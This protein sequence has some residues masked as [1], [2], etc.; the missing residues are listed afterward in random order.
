MFSPKIDLTMDQEFQ[1]D[2]HVRSDQSNPTAKYFYLP[3]FEQADAMQKLLGPMPSGNLPPSKPPRDM[4]SYLANLWSVPLLTPEQETHCYTKLNFLRF[5]AD[6]EGRAD[7]EH[8]DNGKIQAERSCI[9]C[10]EMVEV[11]KR[12]FMESLEV[13]NQIVEAN[14]RLVISLAKKYAT[15]GSDAFDEIVCGGNATLLRAVDRFDFRREVRF[16]TYAFQ[17]IQRGIFTDFRKEGRVKSRFPSSGTEAAESA[18]ASAI[19]DV[20]GDVDASE[21]RE[22]V[23]DLMDQLDDR[24]R[25]IVMARFGINRKH[26]GVAFHVIAKEIGLSTTRTMQLFHRSLA[27]MRDRLGKRKKRSKSNRR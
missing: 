20:L 13:R 7:R 11:R 25:E 27:T 26:S 19:A 3:V 17:A 10:E 2:I 8:R 1:S 14:L 9:D 24:D 23:I 22:Q 12:Y 18:V 4:P 5:L 6:P 15:Y 16:S 21:T